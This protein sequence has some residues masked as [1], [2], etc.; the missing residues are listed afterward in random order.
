MKAGAKLKETSGRERFH[1]IYTFMLRTPLGSLQ[2][3]SETAHQDR[4]PPCPQSH[5]W[6]PWRAR[7]DSSPCR[8]K[9]GLSPCSFSFSSSF[10]SPEALAKAI[11]KMKRS[12]QNKP[13]ALLTRTV[14]FYSD[15]HQMPDIKLN[16]VALARTRLSI[17]HSRR[18]T[19]EAAPWFVFIWYHHTPPPRL[20]AVI[21]RDAGV[22]GD[23][24]SLL[25]HYY[26][27]R[28]CRVI[29]WGRPFRKQ[30]HILIANIEFTFVSRVRRD[31]D[32]VI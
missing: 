17:I 7:G 15:D 25:S 12:F 5:S 19:P 32:M 20:P 16:N 2:G 14:C 13:K 22:P 10:K 28:F 3:P 4:L 27:P 18:Q 11:S 8:H 29:C 24:P 6:L 9:E 31:S 23:S 26:S 30:M 1:C 21:Y